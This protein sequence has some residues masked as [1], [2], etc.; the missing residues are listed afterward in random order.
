MADISPFVKWAGGKRSIV[1]DLLSRIPEDFNSYFEPFVGGGALFWNI[2]KKENAYLSDINSRLIITYRM[3]RDNAEAVIS[4]LE[5]HQKHHSAEYYAESR[6]ELSNTCD[7][8][9]VASLL[10]YLNKTCYNGLYRVNKSG[11]FN[12]PMGRYEN[13]KIVDGDNLYKCSKSLAHINIF[14]HEFF[15]IEPK[16]GDFVYCDPPYHGTFSSYNESGFGN[17]EHEALASFC[18]KLD[19]QGVW[20]MLSNSD[21]PFIRQLYN[22]FNIANVNASRFISCKGNDRRKENELIIRNYVRR[23]E[24]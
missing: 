14:Q 18:K 2:P 6:M 16:K 8:I 19:S 5:N 3:I 23:N 10:I 22:G 17:K 24:S 12:V 21:T 1:K 13:P 4:E 7:P 15:Q 11:F 9:K 20:F